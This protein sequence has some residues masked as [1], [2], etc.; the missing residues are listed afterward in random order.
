MK[1]VKVQSL[2]NLPRLGWIPDDAM[3]MTEWSGE[4]TNAIPVLCCWCNIHE[5]CCY[6]LLSK[7][8]SFPS[9]IVKCAIEGVDTVAVSPI[10]NT[11]HPL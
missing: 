4:E 6:L 5:D 2:V 1:R 10:P 7:I 3:I 11:F 8:P 9:N